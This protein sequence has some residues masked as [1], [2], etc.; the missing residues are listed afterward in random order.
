[1]SSNEDNDKNA[2]PAPDSFLKKVTSLFGEKASSENKSGKGE[3]KDKEHKQHKK[4]VSPEKSDDDIKL[5]E[6]GSSEP[7]DST[8]DYYFDDED[9]D[10]EEHF[11]T[12]EDVEKCFSH[13]GPLAKRPSYKIR[14]GQV[15]MARYVLD[16]MDNHRNLVVEAGTGVGKTF[17]YLVPIL[18][19][20]KKAVIATY[21]KALQDQL[22]KKDFEYLTEAL[23]VK[24]RVFMLKGAS[25]YV[26]VKRLY[27]TFGIEMSDE[28]ASLGEQIDM[29]DN[30]AGAGDQYTEL[31][32]KQQKEMKKLQDLVSRFV[33]TS[34]MGEIADFRRFMTKNDQNVSLYPDA[35]LV[36]NP[37]YCQKKNCKHYENCFFV[38]ARKAAKASK[39]VVLNQALLCHGVKT[40]DILF[41]KP[42]VVVID[43]AHKFEGVMRDAFSEVLSAEN[44]HEDITLLKQSDAYKKIDRAI[45][46]RKPKNSKNQ[47]E[48]PETDFDNEEEKRLFGIRKN[49]FTRFNKV[50]T[51]LA[52]FVGN[53]QENCFGRYIKNKYTDDDGYIL[54]EYKNN[55]DISTTATER[56][57]QVPGKTKL[58]E[59]PKKE[60][61]LITDLDITRFDKGLRMLAMFISEVYAGIDSLRNCLAE[62]GLLSG[63]I[64]SDNLSA[65]DKGMLDQLDKV[66][67]LFSDLYGFINDIIKYLNGFFSNNALTISHSG[68]DKENSSRSSEYYYWYARENDKFHITRSPARPGAE[69]RRYFLNK[70]GCFNSFIFT[71]A[72]ID[73]RKSRDSFGNGSY[74]GEPEVDFTD[75][76]EGIGLSRK[77]TVCRQV[78]SPFDFAH[79]AL[80]CIPSELDNYADYRDKS[81]STKVL[82]SYETLRMLAPVINAT[83]GGIFILVTSYDSCRRYSDMLNGNQISKFGFSQRR[84]CFVQGENSNNKLI[85]DF[86]KDGNA[87]LVGTKSFWE[88]VDI[89]G[90]ALSLVIIEKIPFPQRNVHHYMAKYQAESTGS[91]RGFEKVDIPSAI[92]DLK[93]GAGRLIRSEK[94]K[95]AVIICAKALLPNSRKSYRTRILDS[96]SYFTIT[97]SM[98]D[99]IELLRKK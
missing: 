56:R 57:N 61:G 23:D 28:D 83:E 54:P 59:E 25:N 20:G 55:Y 93:Q 9:D 97:N 51:D 46:Q 40:D 86:K 65:A 8:F 26:C 62:T 77:D 79:N 80:L 45:K 21:S 47:S 90:D 15:N 76:R 70:E 7:D 13:E 36:V 63:E 95:G 50:T 19:S 38:K 17:G 72:T 41:G 2:M 37:L 81:G 98:D 52:N 66:K 32:K 84:K 18:L 16:A 89:P 69:F 48:Q 58:L 3:K 64:G 10:S 22:Y 67:Q 1:M 43:E 31:Y 91:G 71:S 35:K 94:D 33:N 12:A 49:C 42:E 74:D 92:I 96:L 82:D 99:V 73:T 6:Q 68:S 27:T 60:E 88:G 53:K 44:I 30:N 78:S 5:W 11:V 39:I 75:F 14:Q 85:E 4:S 34:E 24:T 87:I 29:F